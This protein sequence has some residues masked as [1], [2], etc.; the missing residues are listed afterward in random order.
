M[1]S[2]KEYTCIIHIFI[3]CFKTYKDQTFHYFIKKINKN[4]FFLS[5]LKCCFSDEMKL[6]K[7]GKLI[8]LILEEITKLD[9]HLYV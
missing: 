8:L 4:T 5:S 1:Y 3:K 9:I 2:L 6:G 7:K